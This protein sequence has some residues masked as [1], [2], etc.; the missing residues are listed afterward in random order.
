M[1]TKT[2]NSFSRFARPKLAAI[3]AAPSLVLALAVATNTLAQSTNSYYL[4]GNAFNL[5]SWAAVPVCSS[6]IPEGTASTNNG[7]SG[8][9]IKDV[10]VCNDSDNLYFMVELWPSATLQD[11]DTDNGD[12]G[13]E[14]HFWLDTDNDPTTGFL[15]PNTGVGAEEALDT[16]LEWG[17]GLNPYFS[18]GTTAAGSPNANCQGPGW[19]ERVGQR[20]VWSVSLSAT[21]VADGSLC[22]PSNNIN[23]GLTSDANGVLDDV[24]P[25][26]SYTI[27][28]TP[29]SAPLVPST[30]NDKI[31][32]NC[33]NGDVNGTGGGM[34]ALISDPNWNNWAAWDN[35]PV[36]AYQFDNT[37]SRGFNVKDVKICN[38]ETNLYWLVELYPDSTNAVFAN[39]QWSQFYF[40]VDDNPST[41]TGWLLGGLGV[42]ALEQVTYSG[43]GT[44]NSYGIID[45]STGN[46]S[47]GYNWLDG[48]DLVGGNELMWIPPTAAT[49][50]Y[51]YEFSISR[52]TYN[53]DANSGA[54]GPL[55][56]QNTFAFGS[57]QQNLWVDSSG[58]GSRPKL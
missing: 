26:F 38:D 8:F 23:I 42:E 19:P 14:E 27:A 39:T 3:V 5:G 50:S 30:Y 18:W 54:G 15:E 48:V 45:G 11:I 57:R 13:M 22:F 46:A 41:A 47:V 10:R 32:F 55:F 1:N 43:S 35:V 53:P 36:A 12:P 9:D 51:K 17:R 31:T 49:V 21:N 37:S 7:F 56:V 24:V 33:T 25:S 6:I 52:S 28:P 2:P 20:Y 58:S 40:D 44:T 34:G 29:A 4:W 16:W